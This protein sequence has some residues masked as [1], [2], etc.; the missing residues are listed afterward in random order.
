MIETA[1]ILWLMGPT[2]AGKTTLAL[3]LQQRLREAH[4]MA[5]AHWDGDQVRDMLGPTLDFTAESRLRVVD[6][7]ANLAG[8]TSRA[9]VFTI[10]SA[11]TAHDDARQLI[12]KA[13]P[14]MLVG[15]IHCPVE[16]CAERDPKGLYGRAIRGEIST[17]IGYNSP[18]EPPADP[19]IEIDTS[20]IEI[21][22]GVDSLVAFL[23]ERDFGAV[24]PN[25]RKAPRR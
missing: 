3:A 23:S 2:S 15:Y 1:G 18:Y 24:T 17:L 19:D 22:A 6:M 13:L 25:A 11:L 8:V 9:G 16:L 7:L 4:T 12:R 21:N 20:R 5:V 10:V 14:D